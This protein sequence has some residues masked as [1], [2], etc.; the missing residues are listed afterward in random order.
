MPTYEYKCPKCGTLIE[1]VHSIKENPDIKC[2]ACLEEK[3]DSVMERQIS[4]NFG[5]FI[6]KQWTES[7]NYS[8]KKQ[9]DQESK[10]RKLKEIERYGTGPRLQPNV[11]G[12]EVDSWSDAKKLAKEIKADT[13]TYDSYISKE[14]NT[15]KIASVDDSKWKQAKSD[16]S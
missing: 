7:K 8:F 3:I 15:S 14:K 5:G 4:R 12:M 9:K 11:A 16:A 13:S 2:P 6:F 1:T 10:K